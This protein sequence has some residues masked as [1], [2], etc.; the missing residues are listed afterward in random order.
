MATSF[1]PGTDFFEQ[2]K[3]KTIKDYSR[4][5]WRHSIQRFRRCDLKQMLTD[6]DGHPMIITVH[7]C[8]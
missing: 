2:L 8:R 4:V 1:L 5:A 7:F 3:K 6:D